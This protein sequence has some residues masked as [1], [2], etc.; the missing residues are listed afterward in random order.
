MANI[1]SVIIPVFNAQD[2]L[3][4][5]IQSVINQ[6]YTDIQIIL[7]DDGSIDSSG[8]ICDEYTEK[9]KRI[10]TIHTKNQGPGIARNIALD[11][12][13]GD[14]IF[15]L[16][17]DDWILPNTL[18]NLVNLAE[19]NQADIVCFDFFKVYDRNQKDFKQQPDKIFI[20]EDKNEIFKMYFKSEISSA[21]CSKLFKKTIWLGLRFTDI[22]IHE[23]AWIY[24]LILDKCYKVV[25][26]NQKYYSYYQR[27]E[28]R[29]RRCF[30]DLDFVCIEVGKRYVEFIKEKYPLLINYAYYNLVERRLYILDKMKNDKAVK[31]FKSE[32]KNIIKELKIELPYIKDID[33]PNTKRFILRANTYFHPILAFIYKSIKKIVGLNK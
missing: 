31:Q 28:S 14:Y 29:G 16:D 9:D 8:K 30:S 27:P 3:D 23:D 25:I 6:T 12:A 21:T 11:V 4:K 24:H 5:C 18:T 15:F 17:S 32:Y 33:S 19:K 26:T 2:Y 22:G 20:V 1:V 10:N 13:I 7:V